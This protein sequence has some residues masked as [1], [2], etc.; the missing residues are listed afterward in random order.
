M[1]Y[2]YAQALDTDRKRH[3]NIIVPMFTSNDIRKIQT[4]LI[5]IYSMIAFMVIAKSDQFTKYNII[6]H[7]YIKIRLQLQCTKEKG[8][9][10][11]IAS[12]RLYVP[13]H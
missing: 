11:I 10:G 5:T 8:F 9:S 2:N 1:C 12:H 13:L 3:K 7:S 4:K 6:N